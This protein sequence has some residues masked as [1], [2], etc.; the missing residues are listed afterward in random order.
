MDQAVKLAE[1]NQETHLHL[2]SAKVSSHSGI[3][4]G[5]KNHPVRLVKLTTAAVSSAPMI[6]TP[7]KI[8]EN[9]HPK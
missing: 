5:R 1:Y 6:L 3:G 4:G 2:F 7:V 9:R 8:R